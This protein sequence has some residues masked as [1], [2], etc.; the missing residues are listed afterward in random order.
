MALKLGLIKGDVLDRHGPLP[1]LVFDHTIDQGKGVAM[2][3]EP[4]NLLRGQ[5]HGLG[6]K[7]GLDQGIQPGEELDK[8]ARTAASEV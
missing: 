6:L 7:S 4:L 8:P 2:G 3:E 1:W 5:H